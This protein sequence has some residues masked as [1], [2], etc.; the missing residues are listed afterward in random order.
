MK[1]VD[2]VERACEEIRKV[3]GDV[4]VY[5]EGLRDNALIARANG[6]LYKATMTMKMERFEKTGEW[7]V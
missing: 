5:V 4:E 7:T 6:K 3:E 2:F 1:D